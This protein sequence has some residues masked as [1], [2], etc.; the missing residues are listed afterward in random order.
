MNNS[1]LFKQFSAAIG[2]DIMYRQLVRSSKQR[3]APNKLC[4]RLFP[5]A[6]EVSF[7]QAL[8]VPRFHFGNTARLRRCRYFLPKNGRVS[9]SPGSLRLHYIQATILAAL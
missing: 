5:S 3:F 7:P 1:P 8:G 6:A 9:L 4:Y 2:M